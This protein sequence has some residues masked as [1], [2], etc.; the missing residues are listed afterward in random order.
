MA[1][2]QVES[3][4]L[5]Q[6]IYQETDNGLVVRGRGFYAAGSSL[7]IDDVYLWDARLSQRA[8]S[9]QRSLCYL[10]YPDKSAALIFRAPV[11]THRSEFF[12]HALIG[13]DDQLTPERAIASFAWDWTGARWPDGPEEAPDEDDLGKVS[14]KTYRAWTDDRHRELLAALPA[15]PA[16]TPERAPGNAGGRAEKFV[17]IIDR[18]PEDFA[19]L[20]LAGVVRKFGSEEFIGDGFATYE[21]QYI[22][23]PDLPRFVFAWTPQRSGQALDRTLV[24]LRGMTLAEAI[25]ELAAKVALPAG[26][27]DEAGQDMA[28]AGTAPDSSAPADLGS[29]GSPEVTDQSGPGA[30]AGPDAT[31]V[32]SPDPAMTGDGVDAHAVANDGVG[33]ADIDTSTGEE[34]VRGNAESMAGVDE[35]ADE[36]TAGGGG[37]GRVTQLPSPVTRENQHRSREGHAGAERLDWAGTQDQFDGVDA[38]LA[39]YGG[40]PREQRV[41]NQYQPGQSGTVPSVT[42]R[43]VASVVAAKTDSELIQ[44]LPHLHERLD[45]LPEAADQLRMR[46][47]RREAEARDRPP[48]DDDQGKPS[49]TPVFLLDAYDGKLMETLINQARIRHRE[50]QLSDLFAALARLVT[51]DIPA[52][53]GPLPEV[54]IRYAVALIRMQIDSELREKIACQV[55]QGGMVPFRVAHLAG[56]ELLRAH[57][58]K[59]AS[60][61]P[62]PSPPS[63]PKTDQQ[64]LR[65]A[66]APAAVAV[67]TLLMVCLMLLIIGAA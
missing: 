31:D 13:S 28:P 1:S 53:A 19:V 36:E 24:D 14:L 61:P 60:A 17:V 43:P 54:S 58:L 39:A 6:L 32:G 11:R 16:S 25:H 37:R 63:K 29:A 12:A 42:Q 64:R 26:A 2:E 62:P 48:A 55:W 35:D 41:Q 40:G 49:F 46:A 21:R 3:A 23:K 18:D 10:R 15:L 38:H 7:N 8:E 59:V 30:A 22:G 50:P 20:I 66:A 57:G 47:G 9:A 67:F 44:W 56:P 52:V 4:E 51:A 65:S 27:S 33:A 34:G 45:E 5:D